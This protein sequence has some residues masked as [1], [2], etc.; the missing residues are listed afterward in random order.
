MMNGAFLSFER[1][2]GK[3]NIGSSRIR[4]NWV[5]K[6]WPE[7]FG[8]VE[9]YVQGKAYDFLVYQ[10]VYWPKHAKNF[11]GV[12]ILDM[13]DADWY[14]WQYPIVEMLTYMDAVTVST[15]KLKK[16]V[17]DLIEGMIEHG[18]IKEKIPV[19]FVPDRMDPDFHQPRKTK[20]AEAI[21]WAVWYGYGHNLK[22]LDPVISFLKTRSVNLVVISDQMY[23]QADLNFPWKVD[24]VNA[25]IVGH[26]DGEYVEHDIVINPKLEFGKW[27]YKSNNKTTSAWALG[28]PVAHTPEEF[29]LLVSKQSREAE[30]QKRLLEVERD[31]HPRLSA[32]QY[33]EIILDSLEKKQ[34]QQQ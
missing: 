31:Y 29:D 11:K 20:H 13:C 19:Y 24:T 7:A 32:M 16:A 3:E 22:A 2:H 6:H 30:A 1:Y 18:D 34:V 26:R 12:K 23:R 15:E 28:M 9:T 27:Q 14:D 33:V 21:K 5:M 4:A 25:D 10:K 8:K 17:E